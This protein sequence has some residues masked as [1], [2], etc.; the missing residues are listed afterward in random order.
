MLALSSSMAIY[1]TEPEVSSFTLQFESVHFADSIIGANPDL[2]F[3]RIIPQSSNP[4]IEARHI[5]ENLHL[6]Y[7]VELK[8]SAVMRKTLS[9]FEGKRGL[10]KVSPTQLIKLNLP[11]PVSD[12]SFTENVSAMT[13]SG[14]NAA[15][16][17]NDPFYS[18][19]W[20][21]DHESYTN[22]NLAKAWEIEKG[23]PK[24]IV[25]VMDCWI[26][27]QHPDLAANMWVNEAELYGTPGV[28]DD[29]NGYVDDIYGYNWLNPKSDVS[30]NHGTHIAGTIAAVN[31]NG[32]GGC[33][34]AGGD[35]INGGV[36]IMSQGITHPTVATG[37]VSD[38]EVCQAFV[39]AADNG[40]VISSN[41]WEGPE[42]NK[43]LITTGMN[44]F[45]RNAGQY[46]G[47]PMKGG[48]IIFAAGNDNK[49]NPSSPYNDTE[50]LWDNIIIVGSVDQNGIKSN[51][52][53]YGDWVD[54]M[55]PGGNSNGI[56]IFSTMPGGGYYYS[57]GTSMA[58]P[59]VSGI[60]ALIVSKYGDGLLTPREVK[61]RILRGVND[62]YAANAGRG[63][64]DQLG[65]GIVDAYKALVGNPNVAPG[66]VQDIKA[67]NFDGEVEISFTIPSDGNGI[68]PEYCNV[69]VEG[70]NGP[71][72]A[73]HTGSYKPG[74]H[75]S[76]YFATSRMVTEGRICIEAEDAWGNKSPKS[77][78]VDIDEVT[79]DFYLFNTYNTDTFRAYKPSTIGILLRP[80]TVKLEFPFASDAY[81]YSCEATDPNGV[82]SCEINKG[83]SSRSVVVTIVP[84]DDTPLGTF[85]FVITLSDNTNPAVKGEWQFNYVVMEGVSTPSGPV[86]DSAFSTE[87]FASDYMGSIEIDLT[88]YFT[89]PYGHSVTFDDSVI[90]VDDFINTFYGKFENGVLSGDYEFGDSFDPTEE[91]IVFS[92]FSH[93]EHL[94]TTET[95]ITIHAPGASGISEISAD[96]AP[97]QKGIYTLMGVKLDTTRENLSPGIYIIDGEKVRIQ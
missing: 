78:W 81:S 39:Y 41:S 47:S 66:S 90:E 7:K 88:P 86:A 48:L 50:L 2:S 60:A 51:F 87:I 18:T 55:A 83:L 22:I 13:R 29:G 63:F 3:E 5:N 96:V 24:V 97:K 30:G 28:D 68:A 31:N 82:V 95:H 20:H 89:D 4:E 19:Q 21:Y 93:N 61:D 75:Y 91:K 40:A 23:N 8:N 58:C 79:D 11:E 15:S 64:E 12:I 53:N 44:Y 59:H 16:Y 57:D 84:T 10:K 6:L 80:G 37:F 71:I 1:A 94:I 46:E 17:P 73:I 69:Y 54:V 35:G 56:S 85:P 49:S 38:W 42:V 76:K 34:I 33:G 25:A 27:N 9:R 65:K 70:M 62:V 72:V 36:R 92:V 14:E 74:H 77:E 67:V 45:I 26:D 43:P 52:S 32:I